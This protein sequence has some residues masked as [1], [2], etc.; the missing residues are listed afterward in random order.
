MTDSTSQGGEIATQ[1]VIEVSVFANYLRRVV[2]V[3]LEE[4]DDTPAALVAAL[5]D[6]NAI[7]CMK[8]FLS[9]PQVPVLFVQRVSSKGAVLYISSPLKY[10]VS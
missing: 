10:S 4:A 8:K 6:K 5:K 9:D 2:P 1:A 7:D 3:L